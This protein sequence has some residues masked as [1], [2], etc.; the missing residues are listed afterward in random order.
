MRELRP[1]LSGYISQ[2]S[3]RYPLGQP[4]MPDVESERLKADVEKSLHFSSEVTKM[5]S[6]LEKVGLSDYVT[7]AMVFRE[8]FVAEHGDLMQHITKTFAELR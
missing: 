5:T 1:L 7:V 3:Y 6:R 2:W 4:Q 8:V